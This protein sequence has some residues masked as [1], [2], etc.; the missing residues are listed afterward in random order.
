[1]MCA[2][3]CQS[4]PECDRWNFWAARQGCSQGAFKNCNLFKAGCVQEGSKC[5]DLYTRPSAEPASDRSV[6]VFPHGLGDVACYRIPAAVSTPDGRLVAFAEARHGPEGKACFDEFSYEISVSH[7]DDL[8]KSWSTPS[9]AA[10]SRERPAFNP[11]PIV[12]KSGKIVMVYGKAP[13]EGWDGHLGIG[14][15]MVFSTDGGE[16]WSDELDVTDQF[17]RAGRAQPGPGAGVAVEMSSGEERLIVVSHLGGYVE[18]LVTISDDEGL[19][20][21]TLNEFF[22]LMDEATLAH[23]GSGEILLA[24]RH[25]N[26]SAVGRAVSRSMDYGETWSPITYNH[27]MQSGICEGSLLQHEGVVYFSA[28]LWTQYP[29]V[30]RRE[31]LL[32]RKSEDGGRSWYGDRLVQAAASTGYSALVALAKSW[33]GVMFETDDGIRFSRVNV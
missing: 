22:P 10:G 4:S 33:L 30:W 21:R 26:M 24:M 6:P 2:L 32:L 8:G 12:L 16:S 13:A 3:R 29:E 14:I 27:G 23:L 1:V 25:K 5:W 15:G 28:P 19:T 20:W 18:D 9:F 7:S 17:G 11:Y 31:F